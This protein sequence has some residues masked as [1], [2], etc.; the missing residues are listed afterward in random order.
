[1][2]PTAQRIRA[3]SH[4][5][6]VHTESRVAA[7]DPIELVSMLYDE[8]ETALGVLIA[9]DRAG[10]PMAGTFPAHRARMILIALDAGL[11]HQAGGTLAAS[12]TNIYCGM[13]NRLD[14]AIAER[15]GDG[16]AEVRNGV[17]ALG[18]AWRQLR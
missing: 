2:P 11:D 13:R 17:T 6:A 12:L 7:A 1:M 14:R 16:I 4:Y 10:Q 18:A 5:R 8:L 3:A 15:D 9:L